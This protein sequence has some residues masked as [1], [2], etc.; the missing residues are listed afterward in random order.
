[1]SI[2]THFF[3]LYSTKTIDEKIKFDFEF[4][5]VK[6]VTANQVIYQSNYNIFTEIEDYGSPDLIG[7]QNLNY[8]IQ[9]QQLTI[10]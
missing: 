2:K 4:T 10:G 1:M 7:Q 5:G 6:N 8:Q 3:Y 9:E